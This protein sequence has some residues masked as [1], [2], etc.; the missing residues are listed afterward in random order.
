MTEGMGDKH[1]FRVRLQT[2]DPATPEAILIS[3][4]EWV[5]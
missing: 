5:P 1:Q 3:L 2:N 4:S